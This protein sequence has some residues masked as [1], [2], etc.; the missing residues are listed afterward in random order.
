MRRLE[1][2]ACA[3]ALTCLVAFG[4]GAQVPAQDAAAA[5]P[6][7]EQERRGRAIYLRG[8]SPAGRE[9]AAAVGE[10]DV[11][12]TTVTCA[13]CHG[14]RGEGKTEGGVTAGSLVWSHLLKPYG[15][16]HPTGRKHGPFTESS[17]IRAVTGGVDPA[18]N[19]LL[20][21]MPRYRMSAEDMADLIAYLKRIETDRDPGLTDTSVEVGVVLPSAGALAETGASMRAVLAAFF[22]DLNARGGV[23][24]RKVTL[25]VFDK[26]EAAASAPR[27]QVFAFVG[28]I[29]AGAEAELAAFARSQEIPVI[30]PS[31]LMPESG[32]P[33]NRYVFYLLPGVVEQARALA[34]F[35]ASKPE[36]K[37]ARAAV[38]YGDGALAGAAAAAA[39]EQL[40]KAGWVA[41][42]RH[43]FKQLGADG[44]EAA[45]RLKQEGVES[46]FIFGA[47]GAE[48]ALVKDATAT[49]W[50]PSL[51]M[52]GV[53]DG[54]D[55]LTTAP[56][57]F[58]ERIFLA[59]PTVPSDVTQA[60]LSEFRALL[61]KH[62]VTSR[63]TAAQLSAFA[64]AKIFVEGLQRVGRDLTRERLL[65]A[66]EGLYDFE[67]G[68]TPRLTFG[69]N[70]RVGAAGAYVM[71][72]NPEKR[73]FAPASG[74]VK[75]Y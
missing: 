38:V 55:L 51:F 26:T 60:G 25:R 23:Y 22:E 1:I 63:H 58:K 31:T 46:V 40:K 20:T 18:G 53:M 54:R 44:A 30:G 75:A 56:A 24:N 74:W 29:S 32:T 36:L 11:P 67:T 6:L 48:G 10:L 64:A 57:A 35:A 9:I 59:F 37:Q 13:G 61:E 42:T 14:A 3:L 8:E 7:V 2:A 21:A 73:E 49:G 12:S 41:V 69:P 68:V 70:R 33:P 43:A 4:V 17:F 47:G 71:T 45:R 65:T 34:N 27:E 16:T 28:G 50:S 66:L 39:E 15:H 52:L 19:N 62:G 5:R 72:I